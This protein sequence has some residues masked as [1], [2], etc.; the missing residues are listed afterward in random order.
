MFIFRRKKQYHLK[1]N[2]ATAV[3][4]IGLFLLSI[5]VILGFRWALYEPFVI[6][7][8]SMI[9]NLLI[10][11]HILV[12]KFAY[13]VRIPFT[14]KWLS[15]TDLPGRGEV[16]VF[17]SVEHDNIF[18]VKR[19]IAL[20]GDTVEYRKDGVLL[21]NDRELSFVPYKESESD[22]YYFVD[23][24]DLYAAKNDYLFFVE[25]NDSTQYRT[26][27]RKNGH[28]WTE[29]KV[30]VPDGHIFVMGD[31]R[32]NSRDSRFWGFLPI[33]HLVGRAKWVWLSCQETLEAVPFLCDPAQIRWRRFFHTI[34]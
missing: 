25:N 7:S 23:E 2:K 17:F 5:I 33:T 15:K 24:K 28:R 9:P 14:K 3:G 29:A 1:Q 30:K 12:E 19:V 20:P 16:V 34:Q 31:N 6:P 8:G 11:D 32:D 21:I 13:G 27:L 18:M 10:H 26:L 4:S 22:R